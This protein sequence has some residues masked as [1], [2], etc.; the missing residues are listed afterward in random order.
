MIGPEY[1]A[2]FTEENQV[3]KAN[4]SINS[5]GGSYINPIRQNYPI[6]SEIDVY[7]DSNNPKLAYVLRYCN[8]KWMFWLMFFIGIAVLILDIAILLM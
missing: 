3:L 4:I 6:I 5:A 8:K 1:K 2:E 7:Y